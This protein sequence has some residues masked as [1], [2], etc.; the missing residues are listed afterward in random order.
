[1]SDTRSE[2]FIIL[3]PNADGF[4]IEVEFTQIEKNIKI[5]WNSYSVPF[6]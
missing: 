2:Q 6:K 4:F 3:G 1:M 5:L